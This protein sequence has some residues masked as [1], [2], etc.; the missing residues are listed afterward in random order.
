MQAQGKTA[1][2]ADEH[3]SRTLNE[4]HELLKE[5]V[6]AAAMP[7]A[8]KP[9]PAQPGEKELRAIGPGLRI[10]AERAAQ[11][12]A[13][14]VDVPAKTRELR[15]RIAAL[16]RMEGEVKKS[17]AETERHIRDKHLP[18]EILA[19]HE[20]AVAEYERRATEFKRLAA[21]VESAADGQGDLESAL[22]GLG[23]FMAKYP[24]AK[25][26]TPTDPNNLPW[27]SPKPVNRKPYMTP[28]QFKTSRL[29]GEPVK[30]AQAGSLSGIG[31][32][33]TTLPATPTPA[34]LAPTED[35]QITQAIRDLAASLNNQPVAIYNWVRNNIAF[36]PSY[37]SIQGAD[38]TLQTRR[39]NAFDTASLLIAL[40]RAANVP[41]RYVYGTIEVPVEKAMNWVGGVTVPEA[42]L[43]L[44]GQGGIPN[45]GIAQGGQVRWID[46]E[47]VW[48]EA[49][50]DYVPSRGAVNRT[51]NTWVPLDA[52]FKQYQFTQGMD[53]KSAIPFDG[54]PFITQIQQSA[55][56]NQIEGWVQN[57]N[58]AQIQQAVDNYQAQLRS[59]IQGQKADATVNDALG[60]QAIIEERRTILLGTLPYSR[61]A[62]GAK[63]QEIPD[64]LRWKFQFSMYLDEVEQ[65][66][67]S[68]FI[69][70]TVSTASLAGKK[71]TLS[72]SPANSSDLATIN[73][74][75]PQP[76]PDG[77]PI[78]PSEL[79]S[80]LPGYLIRMVPQLRVEGQVVATGP[81]FTMGTELI[82]NAAYFNPGARQWESGDFN[83]PVVG[84]NIATVLDLQGVSA[85]Q[86][87]TLQAR[88]ESTKVKLEQFQQ[89]PADPSGIRS[90]TKEDMAGDFLYAA[91]LG[92]FASIDGS[93]QVFAKAA[94]VVTVRMPSFG[95]F[96]TG[97]KTQ[98]YFGV[99]RNV[100]FP[101]VQ[102][103][104]DR[105]F[106]TD[107]SM[108]GNPA[109]VVSFRKSLGGQYSAQEHAIPE[110]LFTNPADPNRLE[111]ISAVKALAIA[112]SQGQRIYTLNQANSAIHGQILS[113]LAIDPLVKQEIA[114]ALAA[115]REVT[116]HQF[117]IN[118]FGF[119][120]VGYIITDP[121][122]GAG[123]YKISG[124]TN[125]ASQLVDAAE[126]K[127]TTVIDVLA[128]I[129]EHI[130]K[131]AAKLLGKALGALSKVA[132]FANIVQNC[133]GAQLVEG[134]ALMLGTALITLGILGF[135]GAFF[136]I[137]GIIVLIYSIV[138]TILMAIILDSYVQQE[139]RR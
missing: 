119:T 125:G 69:R 88:I 28:S 3:F 96:G 127:I 68:A 122:T 100:S 70:Q 106:G 61:L 11:R 49:Y 71:I 9:S 109:A 134:L 13:W 103:D 35:V 2:S 18:A 105:V 112:S 86:L 29:F 46:L 40:L 72:F 64:N 20:A 93:A 42:A 121:E 120:G 62:T 99:P 19:R 75:L 116:V 126:V 98:Y 24:N 138:M 89:N 101:T 133:T 55:T 21:G 107:V 65:A 123:A 92:Y 32:P 45:L 76:H 54:Q 137:S 39:G 118:A 43:N 23:A 44:M 12:T 114:N 124:G 111:A 81:A 85:L 33:A 104:V 130:P 102:M 113:Q 83:R 10:E 15:A 84:E 67:D 34:D 52:S 53:L 80:S 16:L 90:L 1:E 73:S 57:V 87:L 91:V 66:F 14:Q 17:F 47:H 48:V 30:V 131:A 25:T 51:P 95:N 94:K 82:Q 8:M 38:M 110:S 7:R 60:G 135:F 132:D 74:F 77:T 27:G 63:F 78:D 5:L 115:G 37:G 59:Y 50:V 58:Q 56:V 6:P 97:A 4:I 41:A 108:D 36:I 139:C 128:N 31:L 26:H 129:L 136:V 22:S 117:N 79:P